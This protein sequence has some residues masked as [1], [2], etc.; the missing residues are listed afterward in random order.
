MHRAA[1]H[2]PSCLHFEMM[3][4]TTAAAAA[5]MEPSQPAL[6]AVWIGSRSVTRICG[7]NSQTSTYYGAQP[8][9]SRSGRTPSRS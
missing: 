6:L 2:T 9:E 8:E 7:V 4:S 3:S 1:K 5:V